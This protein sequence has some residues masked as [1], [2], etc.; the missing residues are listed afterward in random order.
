MALPSFITKLL[1]LGEI[2]IGRAGNGSNDPGISANWPLFTSAVKIAT[3][4]KT[5]PLQTTS[6]SRFHTEP[7]Q[8]QQPAPT[9]TATVHPTTRALLHATVLPV[10]KPTRRTILQ[11]P[12]KTGMHRDGVRDARACIFSHNHR[13]ELQASGTIATAPKRP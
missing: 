7:T 9:T 11:A 8:L 13:I 3:A 6:L 1:G 4:I 5:S 12:K 10:H 2:N